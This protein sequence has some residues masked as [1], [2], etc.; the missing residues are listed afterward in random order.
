MHSG[1]PGHHQ[2]PRLPFTGRS[3]NTMHRGHAHPNHHQK[4]DHVMSLNEIAQR[5]AAVLPPH[6]FL[7]SFVVCP[8][9]ISHLFVPSHAV[10]PCWQQQS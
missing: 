6:V 1:I 8:F 4:V 3:D 5:D 2:A 10:F 9:L 7:K